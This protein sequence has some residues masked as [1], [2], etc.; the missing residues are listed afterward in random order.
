[1]SIDQLN[2]SS[3]DIECDGSFDS[4]YSSYCLTGSPLPSIF[5]FPSFQLVPVEGAT[6][7]PQSVQ[8]LAQ[9]PKPV[10]SPVQYS[11]FSKRRLI[12]WSLPPP[13]VRAAPLPGWNPMP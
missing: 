9:A 2:D 8:Q 12:K 13:P 4:G 7:I 3:S 6:L 1:M 5:F 10:P 11:G